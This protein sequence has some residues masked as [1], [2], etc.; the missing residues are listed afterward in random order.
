MLRKTRG[1]LND[2]HKNDVWQGICIWTKN[3]L[4]RFFKLF[5]CR[6]R[7]DSMGHRLW[8][9]NQNRGYC[10]EIFNRVFHRKWPLFTPNLK[11][12]NSIK[13]PST[14]AIALQVIN[15]SGNEPLK[16]VIGPREEKLWRG[17]GIDKIRSKRK[18][19]VPTTI[20]WCAILV[21]VSL[22]TLPPLFVC[23]SSP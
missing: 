9:P 6:I 15:L 17:K 3:R 21:G 22:R 23:R 2:K 18:I 10:D 13:D 16:S 14:W 5:L 8:Y 19:S 1:S 4:P 11:L 7:H 12:F 20:N